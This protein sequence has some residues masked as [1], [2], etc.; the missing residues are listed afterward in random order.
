MTFEQGAC[1]IGI[2]IVNFV[3]LIIS[4]IFNYHCFDKIMRN[5][6]YVYKRL[7]EIKWSIK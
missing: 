4:I 7:K 1:I 2:C 5:Q 3:L 6:W